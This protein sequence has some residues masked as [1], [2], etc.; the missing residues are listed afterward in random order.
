MFRITSFVCSLGE[1]NISYIFCFT[2]RDLLTFKQ[3]QKKVGNFVAF[4]EYLN[5][6]KRK[7]FPLLHWKLELLHLL[8]VANICTALAWTFKKYQTPQNVLITRKKI[9]SR[10]PLGQKIPIHITHIFCQL[11]LWL[12]FLS[13]LYLI[14]ISN[15]S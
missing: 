12:F 11:I 4:S 9:W 10:K 15:L 2:F 3:F 1:V 6:T 7:F 14:T 8:L 13:T 5:S